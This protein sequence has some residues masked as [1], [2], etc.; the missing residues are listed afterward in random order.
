MEVLQQV[1]VVKL[2]PLNKSKASA[3]TTYFQGP[4]WQDV[5]DTTNMSSPV[6]W[7]Q[8]KAKSWLF[9][10]S[11]VIS[12]NAKSNKYSVFKEEKDESFVDDVSDKLS[13]ISVAS[14]QTPRGFRLQ[15]SATIP[16]SDDSYIQSSDEGQNV[17]DCCNDSDRFG[18]T[19]DAFDNTTECG[20]QQKY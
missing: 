16:V 1:N 13:T 2:A 14:Q 18:A 4:M 12:Q 7:Q 10:P 6:T 5:K 3:T 11:K 19:N 15:M 8:F 9:S 20:H 17:V